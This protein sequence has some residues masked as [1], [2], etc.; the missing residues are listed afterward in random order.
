[1]T[2]V[3]SAQRENWNG[4]G[5]QAWV[6]DADRRD[7]AL[8]GIA[9]SLLSAAAPRPGETVLDVG[10]GCGA[11]SLAVARDVGPGGA[12]H[13]L[14][15][16][17]VMLAV[18]RQRATAAGLSNLTFTQADVQTHQFA[19]ATHD[20]AVSRFGTMF[21][22]DALAA[23]TNVAGALRPGGRLCIAT[24]QPLAVNDWLSIPGAVLERYGTLPDMGS[25]PGMFAQSDPS[26]V[27][28]LL[29][30]AGFSDIDIEPIVVLMTLG[31]TPEIAANYVASS[32]IGRAVLGTISPDR[33]ASALDALR[34]VMTDHDGPNGVALNGSVLIT[35]AFVRGD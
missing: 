28:T 3:N 6:A 14:D 9:D 1:M 25:G 10:C 32:G 21:F 8:A 5:G 34:Q 2:I 29:R 15:I 13:G 18:A 30:S 26:A 27:T 20:L 11:T 31:E 17:D 19:P 22:E 7:I 4:E 33:Q 16:S 23:F 24:W 12:V 35:T